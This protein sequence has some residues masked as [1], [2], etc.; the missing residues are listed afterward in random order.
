M[1]ISRMALPFTGALL[2]AA[3]Q[4]AAAQAQAG[5][6]V[7][8]T[9]VIGAPGVVI[10]PQPYVAYA[11]NPAD[12]YIA[13]VGPADVVYLNGDTF[14]WSIDGNGRRYRQFYAHGDRRGEVFGRRDELH[15]VMARNGGH[16]PGHEEPH[17]EAEREHDQHRDQERRQEENR[18]ERRD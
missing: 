6:F 15:R 8:P 2:F 1:H 18:G 5:I 17:R 3:L 12:V 9:I 13:N 14:V 10:A 16:L 4:L 11:P 7:E